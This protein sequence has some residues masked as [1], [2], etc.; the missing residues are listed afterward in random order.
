MLGKLNIVEKYGTKILELIN[1]LKKQ[2]HSSMDAAGVKYV[3][4]TVHKFNWLKMD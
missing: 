1:I 4:S 3:F 2:C